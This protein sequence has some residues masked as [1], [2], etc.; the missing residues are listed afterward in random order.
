MAKYRPGIGECPHCR[1]HEDE[2]IAGEKL[3]TRF[4][5]GCGFQLRISPTGRYLPKIPG[6]WFR[7]LEVDDIDRGIR[8]DRINRYLHLRFGLKMPESATVAAIDR[9]NGF[10]DES[11][12]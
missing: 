5:T 4:C 12:D 1:A 9:A 11:D 6:N 7:V 3:K 2:I 8:I 10:D